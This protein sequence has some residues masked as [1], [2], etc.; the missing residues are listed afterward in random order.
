MPNHKLSETKLELAVDLIHELKHLTSTGND[1][2]HLEILNN[3]L[4]KYQAMSEA[5]NSDVNRRKGSFEQNMDAARSLVKKF[6]D[7]LKFANLLD[8]PCNSDPLNQVRYHTAHYLSKNIE[9]TPKEN[10]LIRLFPLQETLSA[11]KENHVIQALN[12]CVEAMQA[13]AKDG[14]DPDY[15]AQEQITRL[16]QIIAG[17]DQIALSEMPLINCLLP[18]SGMRF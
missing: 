3:L 14:N 16:Q 1:K 8:V 4:T 9:A 18:K 13:S 11:N 5:D 7:K 15:L 6:Y 2:V 17:K 10:F 12:K